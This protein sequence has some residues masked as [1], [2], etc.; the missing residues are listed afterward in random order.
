MSVRGPTAAILSLRKP[1]M[2]FVLR[3]SRWLF[4]FAPDEF[5]HCQKKVSKDNSVG[6]RFGRNRRTQSASAWMARASR[7]PGAALA[8]RSEA[9]DGG[10]PKTA[11]RGAA[12]GRKPSR[13][14]KD[15]LFSRKCS[16]DVVKQNRGID[17]FNRPR[18][19][20]VSSRLLAFLVLGYSQQ[21]LWYGSLEGIN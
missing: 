20:Y 1:S 3:A 9:F 2:V 14:L 12:N 6:S 19:H 18:F 11:V 4:K 21:S 8:L 5:V 16:L 7:H 13:N 17:D 10:L 15:T